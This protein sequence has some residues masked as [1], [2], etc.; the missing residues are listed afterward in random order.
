[1]I[2]LM[3]IQALRQSSADFCKAW[4]RHEVARGGGGTRTIHHP[5]AGPLMFEHAVFHPSEFPEQRLTLYSPVAGSGTAEKLAEMLED[6][7][8]FERVPELV[9]S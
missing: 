7:G 5:I 4:K 9:A 2:S 3:L 1:M 6:E 8:E